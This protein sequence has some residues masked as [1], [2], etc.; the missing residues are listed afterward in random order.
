MRL[1]FVGMYPPRS[2]AN[3]PRVRLR[4]FVPVGEFASRFASWNWDIVLAPLDDSRFNRSKSNIKMLEASAIGAV[5]L[6]SPV[7]PYRNFCALNPD[8]KWLQC[9]GKSDWM[10]KIRELVLDRD[11]RLEYALKIRQ[12]AEANF[13]Q[14][15]QA[16]KWM[17]MFESMLQ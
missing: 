15:L 10:N 6:V 17:T 8:L 3:H 11:L 5:C 2:L 4:A 9:N 1:E 12:T 16:K 14:G 13:E 7:A